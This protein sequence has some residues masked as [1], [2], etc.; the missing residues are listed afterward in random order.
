MLSA[1]ACFPQL[2]AQKKHFNIKDKVMLK[3]DGKYCM[4]EAE[5]C[6]TLVTLQVQSPVVCDLV[7]NDF[8]SWDQVHDSTPDSDFC[9]A[10]SSSKF[11][12]ICNRISYFK[13]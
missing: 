1:L 7:W 12:S 3:W 10:R 6:M 2:H 8:S 13:H 11:K 9:Y 4:I 5:P